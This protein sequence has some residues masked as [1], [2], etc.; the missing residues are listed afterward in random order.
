MKRILLSTDDPGV[1][2]VAQYNHSI[3]CG[4]ARKGFDVTS[5]HS[6]PYHQTYTQFVIKQQELGV[7]HIGIDYSN[8]AKQI[9]NLQVTIQKE[10]EKTD[11]LICSNSNPFSNL[12]IKQ[13]ATEINLPYIIV[14]GLVEPHLASK[15]NGHLDQLFHH[16]SKARS[17][18]AVS[19]NNLSLLHKLFRLPQ[20][21]GQVIYYG[22]PSNYFTPRNGSINENLRQELGIPLDAVVCLTSARIEK[23]KGY[24]YQMQAIEQ[25][26]STPVWDN[27]YFIWVGGGVF[28]PQFETELQNKIKQL[29]ITDKVKFL[30][31]QEDVLKF[32]DV[33]DIF[34]LTSELEGMPLSVMEAMSKGLPVIATAVSGMPEELGNTGQLIADP[35]HDP[36]A[37]VRELCETLKN[38]TINIQLRKI[39]GDNCK[40]RAEKIFKEE[41]MINETVEVIERALLPEKDYVS[42]G[43]I[44]VQPDQYFPNMIVGNTA[45][46]LWPYLRGEIPHN[47]YVDRR[48]PT[49][50]FLS[51]DEAQILY[52]TAL[53]FKNKNSLEIGCWMGWSACH[54]AL[55][56]VRLD[57]ID[58]ILEN[59]D[60]YGS[61]T[62]SLRTAGVLDSINLV[63]GYSPQKVEELA[64]QLQKKWSLIFIDGNHESPGPL[65]D[66][67]TCEN[68]A[69]DDAMI[70]FHDLASPDV[71]EGLHYLRDQGWN[72]MIYQTMQIMGVAWRG[73][74][75]P[76]MH[77]PDSRVTW[78]LPAHLINY[79]VSNLSKDFSEHEFQEILSV[80]R[81]YTLLSHERLFSL[82]SL[83][84]KVCLEDI[85]G[86][87]VECG[88]YKGGGSALLATI[89]KRYTLRPRLLY[90]FDTFEGMPDPSNADLHNG[91][92]ANE[93]GF[94]AGTLGAPIRDNLEKVCQLL[95][96][97]HIIKPVPG[98]F[99]ETL[100]PNKT[101]IG[102]I[103]FLHADGDWYDST[104]DIF[105][106]LYDNVVPCGMIQIDDY[107]HWEGCKKAIHEF[108]KLKQES[109]ILH[110]IDYTGVWFR[111]EGNCDSNEVKDKTLI[112]GSEALNINPPWSPTQQ[113]FSQ[114]SQIFKIIIDGVFFQLYNTG[115]A[116]VW[117]SLLEEWKNNGFGR[118]I[119]ILDRDGTAP[120]IPGLWYRTIPAYDYNNT[121]ADCQMLQE[122]CDQEGADLFIST[123]YTTP[124][125]T[126]SV[127][128]AYDMIPEI[129]G[130][131]LDEPM[132]REKHRGIAHAS[133]YI[134][135][136]ES[137]A[138]DLVKYFPDI[139]SEVT[140]AHCG[141]SSSFYLSPLE[142]I[143]QFQTKYGINKPYF[144]LVGA[145]SNYKNAILFFQGFAQLQ[146][147]TGFD[148]VCT[149][150]GYLLGT[151]FRELAAGSVVHSLY[152]SDEELR[153]A[154]SGATA[155]VYPSK[156]EG[157]GMPI[158]EA[159]ACG[160]PVITCA[161][162]SIPEV[163][164]EAAIYIK[165]DDI[166]AM[167]DA[168]CEVQKFKVRNSLMTK[169]LEQAKQFS[170]S[171]MADT[172]SSALINATLIRFNLR[173][174]N[175]VIF[176]DWSQ[177]EEVLYTELANIIKTITTHPNRSKITLLID[178]QNISDEDANLALSSVMM[179]LLMEEELELDDSVEI[180]LMGQLN[181]SQWSALSSQLQG[182]IKLNAENQEAIA[183]VGAEIIPVFDL[184]N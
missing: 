60:F 72:T 147:K 76:V 166:D 150:T 92:P 116:R 9:E 49:V 163:A 14:E 75:E 28:E 111:K 41:R 149:G 167:T 96:V 38:W 68:Y 169:G 161:N 7:R 44:I 36:K 159:L 71:A 135:I 6:S 160:C 33:A 151:E 52:N 80:V 178:H 85:P 58:P 131:N 37:T 182:R 184:D 181:S 143:I 134:S 24:Q 54:L 115:I 102:D 174:I 95:D 118:H 165:D 82:Y 15:F 121:D 51:R 50:G 110:Q 12:M 88:V 94:G 26:I 120:K 8:L 78:Q 30:G 18:I 1:G 55:A 164:G 171:K 113:D 141:I 31:Q 97:Q 158:A 130:G 4:L 53:K 152:L 23:R 63:A 87:F 133:A 156:Y 59:A 61:V 47:W 155:L 73:N 138:N 154:Y 43:L 124:I 70:L 177:P 16:Y 162:A 27:L 117:R 170:W 83:A 66:A 65:N 100:P 84:K 114:K 179:N 20:S 104:L 129:L 81:P 22:R 62:S 91:I 132:W 67:I 146:S 19:E 153:A 139:N 127:F 148:V 137:T 106:N 40:K 46:C 35:K 175:L 119:M 39:V 99:S 109:F 89:I 144:L 77:Q 42:P 69:E 183:S 21:K 64:N 57:V 45:R 123:Y 136:S 74:V 108:E 126:P 125:S 101:E 11:L 122:V 105:N 10:L 79:T 93:T 180:V 17:V 2:G 145:G 29:K 112:N 86:N 176:P 157:F 25:L 172:I 48:Q 90:A 103:A 13:I 140:V 5:M 56:G 107:G 32:L 142:E 173:E 98:L 168:L 128:M 34:I 3:L